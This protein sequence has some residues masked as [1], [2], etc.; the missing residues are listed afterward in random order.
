MNK[1]K[2]VLSRK[3]S[4]EDKEYEEL[5]LDFNSLTGKDII[6]AEKEARAL[7]DN[8]PVPEFSKTYQA[9]LGAKAAKVPIDMVM[10]FNVRDFTRVTMA[11]QNFLLEEEILESS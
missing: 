6:D 10:D 11:V 1:V 7:G 4:F 3:Y 5:S 2:V 9:I 8:S